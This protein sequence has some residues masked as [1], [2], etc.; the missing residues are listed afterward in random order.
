MKRYINVRDL[1]YLAVGAG[2]LGSGGGG[3]PNNALLL[4]K[5]ELEKYGPVELIS[6]DNLSKDDL[7]VPLAFMGAPL[8]F[9]ERLSSPK[10]LEVI[11]KE[12]ERY[13]SKKVT[14]LMPAE[15]GGANA[16]T[17]FLIAAKMSI[18]ILDADLLS[19]A[20]PQLQ[21]NSASLQNIPLC[22]AFLSDCHLN[23]VIINTNCN[24]KLESIARNVTIE[25]GSSAALAVSIMDVQ[26]AKIGAISGTVT[27]AIKLGETILKAQE[28]NIDP[29]KEIVKDKEVSLLGSGTI[30]DVDQSIKA[31]FLKGTVII[32]D[33]NSKSKIFIIYE[34]ENLLVYINNKIVAT[35][36]DII[37]VIDSQTGMPITT[38]AF[39]YGLRVTVITIK[40]NKI[41][42]SKE[43][44]ELVGPQ[45]FGYDIDYNNI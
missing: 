4:A 34:N 39:I 7:I 2:I 1:E 41:W 40:A 23:T 36:P 20:F 5:Y 11:I 38:D 32:E 27:Q 37:T 21:M 14:A 22:P 17:P 16:F 19:R 43:G 33:Q 15:I 30:V 44:L 25:M 31:G 28:N 18:P 12:I 9:T 26:S 3:N 35:T 10:E 6:I 24:F 42:Q 29:V 45:A 13:F 8:V